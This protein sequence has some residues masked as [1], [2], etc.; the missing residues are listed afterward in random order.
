MM[1]ARSGHLGAV[2]C[3][4]LVQL[5]ASTRALLDIRQP[6]LRSLPSPDNQQT[7][8]LFGYTLVLHQVD[9]VPSGDRTGALENTR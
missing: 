4:L 8:G 1:A 7:D 6:I 9:D 2:L 3:I 5:L